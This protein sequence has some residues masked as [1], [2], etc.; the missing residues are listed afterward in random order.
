M[1]QIFEIIDLDQS[2]KIDAKELKLGLRLFGYVIISTF[3]M[4]DS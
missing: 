2:G 4:Y 3:S 1:L